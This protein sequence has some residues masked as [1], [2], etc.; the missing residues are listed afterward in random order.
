MNEMHTRNK[1][2]N[3]KYKIITNATTGVQTQVSYK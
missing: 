2:R 3:R 1:E